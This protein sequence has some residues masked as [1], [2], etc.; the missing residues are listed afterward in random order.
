MPNVK[1]FLHCPPMKINPSGLLDR[2]TDA[3]PMTAKMEFPDGAVMVVSP[4]TIPPTPVTWNGMEGLFSWTVA[5]CI[6]F[7]RDKDGNSLRV[8]L[9]PEP[10][11]LGR[12]RAD[13]RFGLI[14]RA[15]D[16]AAVL[17][18]ADG[19]VYSG[20]VAFPDC[21]TN[22]PILDPVAEA[23]TATGELELQR[24]AN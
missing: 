14:A 22:H 12:S 2:V 3:E 21:Y 9:P 10:V 7:G 24:G 6:G 8:S 18:L 5:A 23:L 19:S 13:G 20:V 4:V 16:A 15:M 1:L 17:R 11:E